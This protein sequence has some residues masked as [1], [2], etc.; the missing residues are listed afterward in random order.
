MP[1]EVGQG[2][3]PQV[4]KSEPLA[5]KGGP[6][7]ANTATVWPP[8]LPAKQTWL[9]TLRVLTED[10]ARRWKGRGSPRLTPRHCSFL[11][12]AMATGSL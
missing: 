5:E 7:E 1:S 10:Q 11:R 9:R 2:L 8:L 12:V 4:M 6:T 3:G